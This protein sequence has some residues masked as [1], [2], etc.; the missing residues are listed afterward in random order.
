LPIADCLCGYSNYILS[1]S[2]QLYP[3]LLIQLSY[4][5][6]SGESGRHGDTQQVHPIIFYLGKRER[7]AALLIFQSNFT[8]LWPITER[9]AMNVKAARNQLS[10]LPERRSAYW[11][12]KFKNSTDTRLLTFNRNTVINA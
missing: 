7:Q 11:N 12:L 8:S 3:I 4:I 10:R 2:F 5:V 9:F 6:Y 1:C